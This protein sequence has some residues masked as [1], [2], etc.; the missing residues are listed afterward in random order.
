MDTVVISRVVIFDTIL[1]FAS[2]SYEC[3]TWAVILWE[4]TQA[5]GV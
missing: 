5:D 3:E 4:R 1:V 2:C